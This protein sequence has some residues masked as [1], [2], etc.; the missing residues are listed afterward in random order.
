MLRNCVRSL[1]IRLA[2]VLG[3]TGFLSRSEYKKP[4]V[5]WQHL[6][7]VKGELIISCG[8]EQLSNGSYAATLFPLWSPSEQVTEIFAQP[9]EA[10]E[11]HEQMGR[12]LQA[13]GWLL[14]GAGVITTAA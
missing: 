8:V 14:R 5:R 2:L 4:P 6:L 11:W 13:A 1:G 10:A 9:A 7:F 3:M 12:R